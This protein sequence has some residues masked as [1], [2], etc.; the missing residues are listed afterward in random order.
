MV[1]PAGPRSIIFLHLYCKSPV[2]PTQ[3]LAHGGRILFAVVGDLLSAV[4]KSQCKQPNGELVKAQHFRGL[5]V[6]YYQEGLEELVA[7]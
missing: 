6:P 4:T 2:I 3:P 1:F 7:V 5:S